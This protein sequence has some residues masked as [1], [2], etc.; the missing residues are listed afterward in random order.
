MRIQ[1]ETLLEHHKDSQTSTNN[2]VAG[3]FIFVINKVRVTDVLFKREVVKSFCR[4]LLL[5]FNF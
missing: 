5:H 1:T 2:V 3:S 4:S